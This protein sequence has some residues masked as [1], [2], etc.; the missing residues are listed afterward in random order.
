MDVD[1]ATAERLIAERAVR[2]AWRLVPPLVRLALRYSVPDLVTA[3]DAQAKA[4][5]LVDHARREAAR[6][7]ATV[8]LDEL[9]TAAYRDAQ[10]GGAA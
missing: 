3:L 4:S 1:E 2:D 5:A 8:F 9:A 7:A 10:D 6:A